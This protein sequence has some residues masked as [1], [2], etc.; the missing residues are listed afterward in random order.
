MTVLINRGKKRSL[1]YHG[2]WTP[3]ECYTKTRVFE[4]LAIIGTRRVLDGSEDPDLISWQ[5]HRQSSAQ[6]EVPICD[7]RITLY[8]IMSCA[9]VN[10]ITLMLLY[11]RRKSSGRRCK[12]LA[13]VTDV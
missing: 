5:T 4:N 3:F 13:N 10:I 12:L 7:V 9:R 11:R 8:R 2:H 6:G 1:Y